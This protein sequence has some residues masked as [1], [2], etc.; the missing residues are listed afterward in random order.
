MGVEVKRLEI[1]EVHE[2]KVLELGLDPNAVNLTSIEAIAGAFRRAG[3]FLC[4]CTPATLVRAIVGPL[5][6]LVEDTESIKRLAEDTLEAMTAHGD[7]QEHREIVDESRDEETALLYQAPLSFVCR[8]SGAVLLFGSATDM[9]EALPQEFRQRIEYINHVRRLD[10]VVDEDLRSHLTDLGLVSLNYRTWLK[11]PS[12]RT[13]AEHVS[14]L[15]KL[16]ADTQRSGAVPDLVLLDSTRPT[17]Y[18]RG[19]WISVGSQSG[20]FVARRRRAYGADLWCYVELREGEPQQLIDFPVQGSRWRGCDEAWQLQ[21]AIDAERGEPQRFAV[22]PDSAGSAILEF[23]SPIPLWGRRRL[24]AVGEPLSRR[25]C[26]FA[27]KLRLSDL[28]EEIRFLSD[29]LWLTNT[30]KE[31]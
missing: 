14:S 23:F 3:R 16:L 28:E 15:D 7:F 19:R 2:R 8:D 10:P 27:Y 26:L 18:Y 22:Q 12:R 20:R 4:P 5:R 13:A 25:R 17:G 11:P 6:G 30:T 21:M 1:S 29:E 24:D 9:L 31:P